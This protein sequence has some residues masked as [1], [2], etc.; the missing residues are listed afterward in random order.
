MSAADEKLLDAA[1]AL[2]C[3]TLA[4]LQ[5][6]GAEFDPAEAQRVADELRRAGFAYVQ[7]VA[8]ETEERLGLVDELP[9]PQ[10]GLT[11]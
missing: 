1:I 4:E 10:P 8:I 2:A 6:L 11:R 3:I 5:A 9:A 7:R